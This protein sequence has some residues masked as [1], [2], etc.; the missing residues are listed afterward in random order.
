MKALV[1]G[2]SSGIGKEIAKY[3]DSLGYE[4]ILVSRDKERLEKLWAEKRAPWKVWAD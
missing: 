1:T 3:L 4:L 2:A